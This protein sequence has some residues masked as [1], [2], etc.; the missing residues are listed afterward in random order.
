MKPKKQ[1]KPQNLRAILTTLLV[2]LV[3]GGG[4][5]FYYGLTL[6]QE[7]SVDVNHR[8]AD[9]TASGEQISQLQTLKTQLSQSNSLIEKANQLF[10]NP[11]T[12]QGQMLNDVKNYADAA[13]LGLAATSFEDPATTGTYTMKLTLRQ[14]VSYSGLINFLNNIES[15]LPKLQVSSIELKYANVKDPNSI[16]TGE[17][18]IEAVR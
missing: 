16:G 8:L 1:F 5:L 4:G 18:K 14:P 2:V 7:Y 10:V 6:V 17:I 13:G 3:V 11:S 15:N 9:A 12:Y